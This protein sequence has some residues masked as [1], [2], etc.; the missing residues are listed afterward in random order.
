MTVWPWRKPLSTCFSSMPLV[1]NPMSL[2]AHVAA[3]AATITDTIAGIRILVSTPTKLTPST[4]APMMTAPTRPPNRAWEELEGRPTSQVRRFHRMA[5]TRPANMN[6]GP[7]ATCCSLMSPPEMVWATSV[8]RNAP[9][10]FSVPAAMTA[11]RGFRA[12]VAMDVAIAFA[13]S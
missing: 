7:I 5:P 4:P 9:M 13:V 6:S 2:V 3:S 12:P 8:E 10:R 11:V 1:M